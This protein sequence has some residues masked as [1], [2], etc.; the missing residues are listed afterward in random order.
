[1]N[2][3]KVNYN[4]VMDELKILADDSE[5]VYYYYRATF[6]LRHIRKYNKLM[7]NSN[8][9]RSRMEYTL[10]E[11]LQHNRLKK[12]KRIIHER[13]VDLKDNMNIKPSSINHHHHLQDHASSTLHNHQIPDIS[14]SLI[15]EK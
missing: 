2:W 6:F 5:Y 1:M 10:K 15:F 7:R 9:Y 8:T 14:V 3:A 13:L 11:R 4:R 12:Q